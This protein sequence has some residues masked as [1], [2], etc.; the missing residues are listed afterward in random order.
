MSELDDR[1]ADAIGDPALAASPLASIEGR[2]RSRAGRRDLVAVAVCSLLAVVGIASI[3]LRLPAEVTSVPRPGAGP[4]APPLGLRGSLDV[5][6]GCVDVGVD[7]LVARAGLAF[8]GTPV[9]ARVAPLPSGAGGAIPGG[10]SW[11][12]IWTFDVDAVVKGAAP[13]RVD[14]TVEWLDASG[15]AL[16]P[17]DPVALFDA[18]RDHP[19]G[20]LANRV[21]EIP[22]LIAV[23]TCDG[24]TAPPGA[25]GALLADF[26]ESP[27]G[28]RPAD[29]LVADFAAPEGPPP[30]EE[31]RRG[32]APVVVGIG[33]IALAAAGA[34]I[35]LARR[36]RRGP[37]LTTEADD[38]ADGS[39]GDLVTPGHPPSTLDT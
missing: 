11:R 13:Q 35:V 10:A 9:E 5:A 2:A 17:R 38:E 15:D 26:P 24:Y 36:R 27:G 32:P 6:P 3:S 33:L 34:A 19:T 16:G 37:M 23:T 31:A 28:I 22:T 14:V 39:G 30:M 4:S 1:L 21:G 18:A 12:V 20:I 7:V 8:I 29:A 25:L